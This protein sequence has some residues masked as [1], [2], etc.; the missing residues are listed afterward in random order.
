MKYL[1]TARPSVVKL[2]LRLP[3]QGRRSQ[4][5]GGSIL[6]TGVPEVAHDALGQLNQL[7]QEVMNAVGQLLL[8][9]GQAKSVDVALEVLVEV[10]VGVQLRRPPWQE[11]DLDAA[12]LL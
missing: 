12:R 11:V 1:S 2:T 5:L 10:L 3:R 9:V 8:V 6:D 7:E 4:S